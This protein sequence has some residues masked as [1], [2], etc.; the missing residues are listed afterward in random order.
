MLRN[1][2]KH[3]I[4]ITQHKILVFK[5]SIK[6]GIPWRGFMHDFSKYSFT[7]F[8]ES[9][10][11]YTDGKKSPIAKCKAEKGYSEAWLHHK[12]RNKHHH[13]Y[14]VDELAPD[15]TPIIPYKYAAEMLCDKLA[16]GIV[17]R[18]KN[19][20]KEYQLSYWNKE[21]EK[22]RTNDKIR[23]FITEALE[24]IARDGLNKTLKKK[25]IQEIYNKHCG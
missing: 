17:Y 3:F 20:T 5:L 22:I 9:A 12:G 10:K 21:K 4:T 16:A 23:D 14:W 15:K 24:M 13:E 6:A 25:K 19:W 2:V 8:F 18:G 1:I 11:Y 7:E